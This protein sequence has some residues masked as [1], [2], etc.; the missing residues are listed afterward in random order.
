MNALYAAFNSCDLNCSEVEQAVA[1]TQSLYTKWKDLFNNP[2][3]LG[4]SEYEWTTDELKNSLKSIEWDLEDLGM[5]S[6]VHIC[7]VRLV[8]RINHQDLNKILNLT[9]SEVG[10]CF[11]LF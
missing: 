8:I 2:S 1:S 11:S 7:H 3:A 4:S 6:F 5:H 9:G 10:F